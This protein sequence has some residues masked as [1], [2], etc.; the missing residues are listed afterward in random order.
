[1]YNVTKQA[2]EQDPD[3]SFI[4]THVPEL[5]AVRSGLWSE[6]ALAPHWSGMPDWTSAHKLSSKAAILWN[7]K[8]DREQANLVRQACDVAKSF[9]PLVEMSATLV[10]QLD[11]LCSLAHV[12]ANAPV[13]RVVEAHEPPAALTRESL[14]DAEDWAR[15]TAA[16]LP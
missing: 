3:G 13:E 14:A 10:A 1:M 4:R 9:L 11:V 6:T 8:F 15:R 7:A 2:K 16:E 5:Q 12:A